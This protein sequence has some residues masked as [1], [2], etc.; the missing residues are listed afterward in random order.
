MHIRDI[1]TYNVVTVPSNTPVNHASE[2][3]R[4]HRFERL[5]V[6]DKGKL[7]GIVTKD[8]LLRAAP[9]SATSLSVW[10]LTYLLSKMT[11]AEIM[12]RDVI[13]VTP[14]TSVE[15]AVALAQEKRVGSLPV[16]EDDRVVGIVTTNDFF[17]KIFNVMLGV[18][19]A[20]TRLTIRNCP[21]AEALTQIC[22]VIHGHKADIVTMS[23]VRFPG[24]DEKD[25]VVHLDEGVDE[26]RRIVEDL[27]AAGYS[28]E[29]RGR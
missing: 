14:D 20:G 17:L 28:V 10:E 18:G 27:E 23:Y 5:P 11:V 1:M 24:R 9:S 6:V 22:D 12:E 15:S 29:I 2:I 25:V 7:V 26:A 13:T 16:V 8:R 3:M 21:T 19:E 4:T